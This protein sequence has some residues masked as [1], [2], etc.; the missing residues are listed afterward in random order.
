MLT[1]QNFEKEKSFCND[2]EIRVSQLVKDK[3]GV[4]A[5]HEW[6]LTKVLDSEKKAKNMSTQLD[7]SYAQIKLL[8]TQ[9]ATERSENGN[10]VNTCL[11][12][13]S[14]IIDLREKITE[15][16]NRI[17]NKE[18]AIKVRD[19]QILTG[20]E[21]IYRKEEAIAKLDRERKRLEALNAS[22]DEQLLNKEEKN[23]RLNKI[24]LKLEQSLDEAE[25]NLDREIKQRIDLEKAKKK[26][27]NFL[28]QTDL[29][30]KAT[31]ESK[32]VLDKL[33]K[34]REF[35]L[36]K[37][38]VKTEEERLQLIG[39]SKRIK[40]VQIRLNEHDEELVHERQLRFKA[41]ARVVDLSRQLEETT[42][43]LEEFGG[44]T[45]CQSEMNRKRETE[46]DLLKDEFEK[47][48]RQHEF[49][50]GKLNKKQLELMN[51]QNMEKEK[52]RK[53]VKRL[54]MEKEVTGKQVDEYREQCEKYEAEK[55]IVYFIFNVT[56]N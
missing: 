16:S 39:L 46:M 50:V 49:V 9:M 53:L 14:T 23:S 28:K 51:E 26:T 3:A 12:Q 29:K 24:K 31:I 17:F 11:N 42:L 32:N 4:R 15:L 10:S 6:Q 44:V 55:V 30:L 56:M 5:Q 20:Q 13:E 22:L 47:K 25:L 37:H 21:T 45:K 33:L 19:Q 7:S 38:V 41:E 40:E 8:E 43:K 18:D 52:L 36:N 54:E 35:E 27:E 48:S 34:Q 1:S 2:L